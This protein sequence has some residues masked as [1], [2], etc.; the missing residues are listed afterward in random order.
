ML[1][2]TYIACLVIVL[3][4]VIMFIYCGYFVT[5][6]VGFWLLFIVYVISFSQFVLLGDGKL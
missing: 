1:R 3:L 6:R 5:H 4:K 2:Y